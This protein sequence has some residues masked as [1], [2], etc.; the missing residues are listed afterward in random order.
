MLR[1]ELKSKKIRGKVYACGE[2]GQG[3]GGCNKGKYRG[4][5]KIETDDSLWRCLLGVDERKF[6]FPSKDNWS[7][8]R[9]AMRRS[10]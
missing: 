5:E 2:G 4:Q 10:K 6:N 8:R 1:T 9:E 3:G 7:N